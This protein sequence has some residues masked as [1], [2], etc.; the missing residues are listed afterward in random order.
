MNIEIDGKDFHLPDTYSEI[1]LDK[2]IRLSDFVEKNLPKEDA[3]EDIKAKFYFDY[4]SYFI[5]KDSLKKVNVLQGLLPTFN[6]LW[7]FSQMPTDSKEPAEILTIEKNV[8]KLCVKL[9][10]KP[11]E[12]MTFEEYEESNAVLTALNKMKENKL[13]YLAHLLAI[14]YRPVDKS[15]RNLWTPH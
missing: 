10:D 15:L 13:G 7:Q 12:D 11:L 1:T 14:F 9:S 8:Y 2:F 3:E 4:C 6:H 5:P